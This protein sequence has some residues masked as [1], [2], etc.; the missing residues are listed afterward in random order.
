MTY[1]QQNG[2]TNGTHADGNV[3][4]HDGASAQRTFNER[5]PAD[6]WQRHRADIQAVRYVS[7]ADPTSPLD[8][9]PAMATGH[10]LRHGTCRDVHP[11][12][13]QHARTAVG[14]DQADR[15]GQLQGNQRRLAAT[16]SIICIFSYSPMNGQ[17][18]QLPQPDCTHNVWNDHGWGLWTDLGLWNVL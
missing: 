14:P 9:E 1:Q 3:H 8:D 16:A 17:K 11:A 4:L 6:D 5:L 12:H 10:L 13:T 7:S 2:G 15:A 18:L